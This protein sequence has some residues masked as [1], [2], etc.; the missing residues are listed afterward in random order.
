M[1]YRCIDKLQLERRLHAT[2]ALI[3]AGA[4]LIE[5]QIR[6]N[7]MLRLNRRLSCEAELK[8]DVMVDVQVAHIL[9]RDILLECLRKALH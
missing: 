7:E 8:L 4:Q 3:E 1:A 2:Q 5:E 9:Y 6:F